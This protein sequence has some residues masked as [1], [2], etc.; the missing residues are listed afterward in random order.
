MRSVLGCCCGG[1]SGLS[2]AA[3][4]LVI[5]ELVTGTGH[6]LGQLAEVGELLIDADVGGVLWSLLS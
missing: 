3:T 6:R 2:V 1:L 5:I 4:G